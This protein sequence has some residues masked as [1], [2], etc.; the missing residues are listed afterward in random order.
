ML[1]KTFLRKKI[2]KQRRAIPP[3]VRR[4]KSRRIFTKIS[5]EPFFKKARHIALYCG[6]APEVIT[7]P[8]LKKILK[9]KKIYLPQTEPIK[10]S[11]KL[12]RIRVLP[13]DLRKGPYGIMEPKISCPVRSATRMDLI[14]VPGVAFD[15]KGGRLGR[16]AGYYD[17]FL[18]KAR[19]V[20]K[21]GLCFR[22]QLVKK[23]PMKKFDMSVDKVITD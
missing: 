7:R 8:F 14:I 11:M 18:R 2:L 10:K 13:G 20:P 9:E 19:R 1:T 6:I 17:R 4:A 22:E 12:R 21:I 5:E 15:K 3:G 23:V 16:G